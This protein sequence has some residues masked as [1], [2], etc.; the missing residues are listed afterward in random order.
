MC[1]V[2]SDYMLSFSSIFFIALLFGAVLLMAYGLWNRWNNR[3]KGE[4]LLRAQL[5]TPEELQ[6][7][8]TQVQNL[9]MRAVV[10]NLSKGLDENVPKLLE[11][12]QTVLH[13]APETPLVHLW[14]AKLHLEL[15]NCF[16]GE[17]RVKHLEAAQQEVEEVLFQG[18]ALSEAFR[19]LADTLMQ[20]IP[21]KGVEFAMEAG[22]R[23]RDAIQKALQLD[24]ANSRAYLSAGIYYL[25]TPA[26]YGGD[27]SKAIKF[28]RKADEVAHEVPDRFLAKVYIGKAVK[29]KGE[30]D[31]AR[32]A[33]TGALALYPNSAW[34]QRELRGL[35]E[36]SSLS[37]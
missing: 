27:L 25:F 7:P 10:L 14:R 4:E 31:A 22:P 17:Q 21:L 5:S 16:Q 15:G 35:V 36:E 29:A 13:Q 37:R 30:L 33:F 24:P 26:K 12:A 11:Q 23:A 19:V 9:Y 34:A 3:R 32:L 2:Y 8:L 6:A 18:L 1:A 28:L 20:Q